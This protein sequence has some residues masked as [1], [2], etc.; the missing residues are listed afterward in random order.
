MQR[1]AALVERAWLDRFCS[2]LPAAATV[3]DVGCGSGVPIALDLQQ[4]GLAVTGV[5]AAPAMLAMFRRNLPTAHAQLADM[6]SLDFGC[7]YDG[8]LAWDSFFHLSPDNQRGM[9]SRFAAHAAPG[10][11]L[12]FTSGPAAGEAIGAFAGEPLYHAS[13]SANE[14]HGLLAD[15]GFAVVAHEIEDPACTNHTIWLARRLGTAA[16]AATYG[17]KPL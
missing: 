5:D 11:A 2:L 13:L 9:F 12:M 4:R 7:Q 14:Y 10:G 1:N 15:A 17:R 16:C 3:L 6:R 8:L